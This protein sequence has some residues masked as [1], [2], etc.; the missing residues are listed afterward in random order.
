[1]IL[2]NI[3]FWKVISWSINCGYWS[4]LDNACHIRQTDTGFL[5]ELNVTSA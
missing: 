2:L 4:L 1:M 3:Y 5:I